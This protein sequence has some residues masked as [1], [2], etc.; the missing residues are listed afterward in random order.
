MF[1]Y[2]QILDNEFQIFENEFQISENTDFQ[3]FE[4]IF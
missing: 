4:I 1:K 3:I 2:F